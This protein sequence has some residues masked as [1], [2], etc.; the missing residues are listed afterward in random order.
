[1]NLIKLSL[2][3]SFIFIS[4]IAVAEVPPHTPGTVCFTE[5]WWCWASYAGAPGSR[6]SC[7][8]PTGEKSGLLDPSNEKWE[9]FLEGIRK[10]NSQILC[11]KLEEDLVQCDGDIFSRK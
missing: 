9:E 10:D 5:N 7:K 11:K 8:T 3:S 6:C 4:Q 1:M 2:I